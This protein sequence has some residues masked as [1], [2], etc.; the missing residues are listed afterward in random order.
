LVKNTLRRVSDEEALEAGAGYCTHDNDVGMHPPGH[1]VDGRGRRSANE[2]A[3]LPRDIAV[4]EQALELN[5]G[6]GCSETLQTSGHVGT[7]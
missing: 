1:L 6:V 5:F 2:M 4:F 3:V 7:N